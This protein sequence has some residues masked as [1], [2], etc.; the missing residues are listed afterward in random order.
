LIFQ[1]KLCIII[2]DVAKVDKD[3]IMREFHLKFDQLVAEVVKKIFFV[4]FYEKTNDMF[5]KEEIISLQE[6]MEV[7]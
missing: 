3:E 4:R 2:K 7:D 1:A 6:C 5:R